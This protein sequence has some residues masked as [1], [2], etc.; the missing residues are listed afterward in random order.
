MATKTRY[1]NASNLHSLTTEELTGESMTK[2]DQALSPRDILHRYTTG[3]VIDASIAIPVYG[4]DVPLYD[5]RRK[6]KIDLAVD[7]LSNERELNDLD[8]RVYDGKTRLRE[9]E[10]SQKEHESK[11]LQMGQQ[12]Q[13]VDTP[14]P[15]SP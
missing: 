14:P 15:T 9:M 1:R 4:R 6:S 8:K 3:Q 13:N 11:R 7:A 12:S 5:S 2:P 10:R